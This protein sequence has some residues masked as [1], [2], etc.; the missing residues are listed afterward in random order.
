M[1][2]RLIRPADTR[3]SGV[4]ADRECIHLKGGLTQVKMNTVELS[5][6]NKIKIENQ[7]T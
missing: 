5:K 2:M 6:L 4:D 7:K 1:R 3:G